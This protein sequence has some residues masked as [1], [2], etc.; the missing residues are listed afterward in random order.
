MQLQDEHRW[1]EG[2]D[3]ICLTLAR[4]EST[5]AVLDRLAP[6][7]R[8]VTRTWFEENG[9]N[10]PG[11]AVGCAGRM[12]EYVWVW[13]GNGFEGATVEAVLPLSGHGT[14]LSIFWNVNGDSQFIA[15]RHGR[16]LRSF[17]IVLH[18]DPDLASGEEMAAEA[19]LDWSPQSSQSAAFG[20]AAS[21]I[22]QR[23]P[24]IEELVVNA[25]EFFW[26][27]CDGVEGDL[28]DAAFADRPCVASDPQGELAA[29]HMWVR[30]QRARQV[31]AVPDKI[32]DAEPS[33]RN[34]LLKLVVHQGALELDIP[35]DRVLFPI[36]DVVCD[37][38]QEPSDDAKFLAHFGAVQAE[39]RDQF[40]AALQPYPGTTQR[41][42]PLFDLCT[43]MMAT[44]TITRDQAEECLTLLRAAVGADGAA[45]VVGG[46]LLPVLGY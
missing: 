5:S 18:D 6:H 11:D 38:A 16:L 28:G 9:R 17:D 32:A 29:A 43:M 41:L 19:L 24:P 37:A 8:T 21:I 46:G 39:A 36:L 25:D 4:G 33:L 23:I 1:V 15:A 30:V 45:R 14:A 3:A 7:R 22:G 2:E 12:G 20:L 42:L 13:E 35:S 31:A 10:G 27:S 26:H 44:P 40:Q 34:Y